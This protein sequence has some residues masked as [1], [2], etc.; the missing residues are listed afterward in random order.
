MKLNVNGQVRDVHV[1]GEM[2]LPLKDG[3]VAPA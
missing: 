3:V 1:E 2:P